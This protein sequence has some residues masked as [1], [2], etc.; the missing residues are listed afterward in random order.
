MTLTP[1]KD[2]LPIPGVLNAKKREKDYTYYEV[3]MKPLLH[4]F[5][6][7]MPATPAWGYEGEIPGP[8][9]ETRRG[10]TVKVKW[11]N[12]LP[13]KHFL[14][15]DHTL[16]GAHTGM[17]EVRTV[18]HLHGAEVEADSDGY[19][20][21]WYTNGNA[22]IGPCYKHEVYTYPNSQRSTNLWYHDHALGITRLNVYAGLAG[23]YIIRD[24]QEDA[25]NLPGGIYEVPIVI[26]DRSF[27]DD[28]TMFYPSSPL[29]NPTPDFP[30][31]S[32]VPGFAGDFITVNGKVWPYFEVEPR[33]YRFRIL[34]ASN[35]RFY[36]LKFDNNLPFIQIGTDG[37][38]LQR[39]VTMSEIVMGP[40]ERADAIVDFSGLTA[41]TSIVLRNSARIPFDFGAPVNP[42]TTG[43]VMEFRVK[44]LNGEDS[45]LVPPFLSFIERYKEEDAV[46][47]RD[48]T[49]DAAR[50]QYGRF[51]FLLKKRGFMDNI[52]ENPVLGDLEIW[53]LFNSG[54]AVHPIHIHLVQFQILDRIPFDADAFN[55]N[56]QIR[57]TG[58]PVKPLDNEAGWKDTVQAFPGFIT[59]LIMRFA[60]YTGRYVF[61]CH[62][63][64]HED[65]DMMRPINVLPPKKC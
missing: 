7:D 46:R 61:H 47:T 9:L 16:H 3:T 49:L 63:L 8:T 59:R 19:P 65:Y 36:R 30:D 43:L 40:S 34:N 4:Q 58:D 24:D 32:V 18:V 39:P 6:S 12:E 42:E 45:S 22:Q 64:E 33:K 38:L 17:P 35:Q 56:G 57:F 44:E 54:P 5:H 27:N 10:E 21:D 37:G 31:P 52:T 20:E 51:K 25:L 13:E 15:V 28:G 2:T 41:G 14:P 53:R 55:R 26:Q 50:D 62:I 23:M 60:P 48:I 29:Q 1:F 11:I